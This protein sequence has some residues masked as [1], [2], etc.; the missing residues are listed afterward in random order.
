MEK[1]NPF[2]SELINIEENNDKLKIMFKTTSDEPLIFKFNNEVYAITENIDIFEITSQMF[3][4]ITLNYWMKNAGTKNFEVLVSENI[5]DIDTLGFSNYDEFKQFIIKYPTYVRYLDYIYSAFFKA[6]P[7]LFLLYTSRISS[8]HHLKISDDKIEITVENI[9]IRNF[10]MKFKT[11][12]RMTLKLLRN[13]STTLL[14]LGN[15]P[16][17]DFGITMSYNNFSEILKEKP[18]AILNTLIMLIISLLD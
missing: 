14:I 17:V 4:V 12:K 10:F 5:I 9:S 1:N 13:H 18:E 3:P 6:R 11:D 8:K 7:W 2:K 15:T 16:I